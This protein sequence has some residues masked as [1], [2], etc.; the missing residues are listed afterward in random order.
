MRPGER[1]HLIGIAGSGAAGVALLLHHVHTP[2]NPPSA[3][4]ELPIPPELD[5][6]VLSCLAKNPDDRPQS[7]KELS[8]RL[9]EIE[10]E[11]AWTDGRAREWWNRHQPG[12]GGSSLVSAAPA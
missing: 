12:G 8:R 9:A 2:P 3:R 6:L 7:A 5:R 1:I 11:S 4:T 10:G